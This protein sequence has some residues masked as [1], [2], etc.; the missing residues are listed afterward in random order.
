VGLNLRDK[1]GLLVF[2]GGLNI[3]FFFQNIR[4]PPAHLKHMIHIF[5][6]ML[7]RELSKDDFNMLLVF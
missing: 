6:K 5:I 3:P 1:K 4:C 2:S 7:L